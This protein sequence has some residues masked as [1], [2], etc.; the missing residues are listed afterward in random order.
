MVK[1][2]ASSSDIGCDYGATSLLQVELV[3]IKGRTV[4]VWSKRPLPVMFT[5]MLV[6]IKAVGS[7]RLLWCVEDRW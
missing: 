5:S 7:K 1:E 4:V 2:E 3:A 6:A